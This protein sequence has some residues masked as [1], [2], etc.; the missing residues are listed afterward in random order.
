MGLQKSCYCQQYNIIHNVCSGIFIHR[1]IVRLCFRWFSIFD[2]LDWFSNNLLLPVGGIF[3]TLFVGWF[4]GKDKVREEITNNG[5]MEFGIFGIRLLI[6][7]FI[8]PLLVALVLLSGMGI[9]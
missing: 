2:A 6:C 4:W 1:A 7:K 3:I 9:I 8:I 5:N